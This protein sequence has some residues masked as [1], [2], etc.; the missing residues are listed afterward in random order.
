[1]FGVIVVNICYIWPR[2]RFVGSWM[3]SSVFGI[4]FVFLLVLFCLGCMLIVVFCHSVYT[5][6]VLIS[7]YAAKV[8][9]DHCRFFH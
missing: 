5:Q 8:N 6:S 3:L 9:A 1:M 4:M 7:D 2:L